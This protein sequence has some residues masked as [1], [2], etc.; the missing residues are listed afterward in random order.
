MKRRIAR[1]LVI[2]LIIIQVFTSVGAVFAE[3]EGTSGAQNSQAV[4][5]E[6][7]KDNEQ[8]SEDNDSE[9]LSQTP[10]IS[11][12]ESTDAASSASALDIDSVNDKV[13]DEMEFIYIETAELEAPGTQNIAI[14]WENDLDQV[15]NANLVLE[16]KD[17]NEI[18]ISEAN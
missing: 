10:I 1:M 7:V 8:A 4:T 17:G 13:S 12:K 15:T 2:S 18:E 16:D 6:K 3:V 14:A 5:N 11:D 9:P